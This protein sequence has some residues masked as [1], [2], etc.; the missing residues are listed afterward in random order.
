M[1]RNS[2]QPHLHSERQ[3]NQRFLFW[4]NENDMKKSIQHSILLVF[5]LIGMNSC[6]SV[7]FPLS[8]SFIKSKMPATCNVNQS[9]LVRFQNRDSKTKIVSFMQL[10][11]TTDTLVFKKENI[12]ISG[13]NQH[14]KLSIG[15]NK[16]WKKRDEITV[17]SKS[18]LKL[19]F[20]CR[21]EGGD[22]IRIVEKGLN[23]K[24][25]SIVV[26]MRIPAYDGEWNNVFW[27]GDKYLYR[28]I[29]DAF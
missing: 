20:K 1:E 17:T 21:K 8:P 11:E 7:P 13:A 15:E 19:N 28:R 18:V 24:G 12:T 25:D 2:F 27:H 14:F 9:L 16:K 6:C 22:T 23:S 3:M 10:I 26:N 4:S 29:Y 5:I